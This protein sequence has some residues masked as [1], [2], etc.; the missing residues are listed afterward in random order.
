MNRLL[1]DDAEDVALASKEADALPHQHLRIPPP[2]RSDVRETLV[3]DVLH[4]EAD[5]VDVTIEH[6]RGRTLGVDLGEAVPGDVTADFRREGLRLFAPYARRNGLETGWP[7]GI[8][9]ALE[10]RE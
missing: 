4:D 8:E 3:V 10:E 6:D 1:P 7:R 9:Q 5:L 2:D